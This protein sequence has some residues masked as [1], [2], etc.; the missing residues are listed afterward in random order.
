V[1]DPEQSVELHYST[2]LFSDLVAKPHVI[3][4]SGEKEQ[5]AGEER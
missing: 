2:I 4:S 3:F 5:M 1:T